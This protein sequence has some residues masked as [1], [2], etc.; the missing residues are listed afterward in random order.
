ML[1]AR[2]ALAT[3]DAFS[4]PGITVSEARGF[5]LTQVAGSEKDLKK[6]L[7][8]LPPRVGVALENEGRIVMRIAPRQVWVL[9]QAPAAA[10]GVYAT[11][12]SSGR[13][14]L[15][16]SGA[17]A[18]AVLAA[19]VAIDFHPSQFRPG[20]FVTTGIHH[21]PVLIHCLDEDSFHIYAMRSFAQAVWE[22]LT[23]AAEGVNLQG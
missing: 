11:P 8:K 13:T 19:C 15:S 18:R 20:Q 1:D 16:L 7:G 23:D 5:T 22:W 10:A 2:S 4:L 12:L 9:G 3:A 21:T 17:R 6:S 14:R